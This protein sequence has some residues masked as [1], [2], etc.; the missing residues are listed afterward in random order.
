MSWR[1]TRIGPSDDAVSFP[2]GGG[3]GGYR[4]V[5][6]NGMR[7]WKSSVPSCL[8]TTE[9]SIKRSGGSSGGLR[10]L[11]RREEEAVYGGR[12]R[13]DGNS[14]IRLLKRGTAGR[15]LE[16]EDVEEEDDELATMLFEGVDGDQAVQSQIKR[17]NVA[18][19]RLV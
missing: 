7:G 17:M 19:L 11:K 9:G 13:R 8:L 18:R 14:K 1:P 3:G 4:C 16:E 15:R 2:A 5:L 6:I 12:G 10:L